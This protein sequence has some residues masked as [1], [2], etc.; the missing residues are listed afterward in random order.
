MAPPPSRRP[1]HSRRAQFGL[2][3]TYVIALVGM[4]IGLLLALSARFD[5]TAHRSIQ[6]T[7]GDVTAPVSASA[8]TATAG[9]GSVVDG[10]TA[11]IDAGSK[12]REM[13]AE[14]RR[15]RAALVRL[16]AIERENHRLRRLVRLLEVTEQPVAVGRLVASTGA[17]AQR[18]ATLTVGSRD[19]VESGQPV[20]TSEGLVG[21]VVATGSGSARVLLIGDAGNV[22][23]V[24]RIGDGMPAL[25]TGRGDGTLE[26]RALEAGSNPF[27]RGD[28]FVTSGAGGVY[29]PRIPVALGLTADREALVARPLADPNRFDFATVERSFVAPSAVAEPLPR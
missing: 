8:R 9:V 21:R 24:A 17:I 2:F 22:V 10:V 25:A 14:A 16:Q 15:N 18:F 11:Y 12:N 27:K 5:P 4:L 29:P 20:R 28:L 3:A 1:G 23:P 6:A 26:I 19:G 7:L 13:E